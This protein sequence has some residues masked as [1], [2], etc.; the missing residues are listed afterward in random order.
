MLIGQGLLQTK[1]PQLCFHWKEYYFWKNKKHNVVA[2]SSVEAK[3][4]VVASLVNLCG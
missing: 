4:R 3:C 2:Q 1:V